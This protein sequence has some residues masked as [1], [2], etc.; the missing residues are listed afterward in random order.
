VDIAISEQAAAVPAGRVIE[1][2]T[3]VLD[4]ELGVDIVNLGLVYG[5]QVWGGKVSL[6]M[7]LT[8]PG[9]PLHAVIENDVR[10]T[11]ERVDGVEWVEVE[12]VWDPPWSTSR[13]TDL[14][15]KQLHGF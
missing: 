13:I 15:R 4:P 5:V 2:L 11:L 9:C 7:T 8:T 12:I 3:G 1:A 14:A 6:R 10:R